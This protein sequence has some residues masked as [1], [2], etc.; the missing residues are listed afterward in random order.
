MKKLA[1]KT[2]GDIAELSVAA[3][4]IEE[5][6]QILFPFGE[7]HRYDLVVEKENKFLR[8][9]IKYVTPKNGALE[10]NCRS[11]NNWSVIHYSPKDIDIIAAYN[12]IDKQIYFI[13]V[14]EIN[15][16]SLKLRLEN[17][18][19][20]QKKYIRYAKNYIKIPS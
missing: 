6:W 5:G 10:I 9:Q 3:K 20:N 1:K 8:V 11:S 13:P 2:K 12:S 17:S 19:N 14:K 7:N 15:Y 4:F 18:K 16:S